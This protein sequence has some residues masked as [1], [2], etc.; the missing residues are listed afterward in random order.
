MELWILVGVIFHLVVVLIFLT[1]AAR[2]ALALEKLASDAR[3]LKE[4]ML[5]YLK[6]MSHGWPVPP[7]VNRAQDGP[8][9]EREMGLR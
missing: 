2:S 9:L 3:E 8:A 7:P 4:G 5:A 1:Q 6:G